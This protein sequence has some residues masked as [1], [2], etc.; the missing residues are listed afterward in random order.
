MGSREKGGIMVM[1]SSIGTA[2]FFASD[3]A[4]PRSQSLYRLN[5]FIRN[6]AASELFSR[7]STS[8]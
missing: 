2:L 5:C 1:N 6:A 8:S 3:K 4:A 7:N